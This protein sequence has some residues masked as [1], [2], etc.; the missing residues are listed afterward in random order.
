[1][2]IAVGRHWAYYVMSL[3]ITLVLALAA[4]TSF[5]AM[6]LL[7]SLLARD[8]YLPHRFALRDDRQVFAS[9][10]WTLA[11]L[12]A[13]LLIAVDGNTLRLIPLFAIGVL[14]G[15]TLA[16]APARDRRVCRRPPVVEQSGLQ[17]YAV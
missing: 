17:L 3:T 2:A 1:M 16:Q 15:F 10:I 11:I 8:N 12:S 6:P 7:A 4:N 5:G 9:G 14:T 13:A